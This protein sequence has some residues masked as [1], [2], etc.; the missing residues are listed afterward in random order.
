MRDTSVVEIDLSRVIRNMGVLRRIVG[1][2]CAICPVVKADAYGLGA[3]RISR[4]LEQA[5]AH[6]LAVFTGGEAS[7]LLEA[8]LGGPVLVLMPL[9]EVRRGSELHRGLA[10]GRLHLTVHDLPQLEDLRRLAG[11]LALALP[12][13]LEVDTGMTRGGCN[14]RDVPAALAGIAASP[15]LKLAGLSTQFAAS[16]RDEPFT[17]RQHDRFL[18]VVRDQAHLVPPGC[19]LHAANTCA[20]LRSRRYHHSMIRVGQAWAGYGVESIRGGP[21]LEDADGLRPVVTW[22]SRI[23]HLKEVDAGTPVGYGATWTARRRS[24][25]GLVPVG[26]AD[27]FPLTGTA[28]EAIGRE[29]GGADPV[30]VAVEVTTPCGPRR[31]Y[32]PLVGRVSMDQITIDLTEL[33]VEGKDALG[34]VDVGARVELVSAES[35]APN[36]LGRLAAAAGSCPH[37]ILSRLNP[38]IRRVYDEPCA[39]V[40]VPGPAAACTG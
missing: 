11:R 37:E 8:G 29:R 32:A 15:Q 3:V 18:R 31:A 1:S 24:L 12:V 5:G 2:G 28:A 22:S 16:D 27:G 26:Y 30:W 4:T 6:G 33:A 39:N 40:E 21:L 14:L 23:I 10:R 20:A 35:S 38:R 7:E 17:R 19:L 9:R 36:H 25:I 13:H 34:L